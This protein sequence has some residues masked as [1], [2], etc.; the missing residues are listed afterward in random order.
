L[1]INKSNG[2]E[3]LYVKLVQLTTKNFQSYF[4]QD[5]TLLIYKLDN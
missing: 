1:K 3:S 4:I 2:K 5:Q